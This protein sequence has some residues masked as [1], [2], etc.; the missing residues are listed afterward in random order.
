MSPDEVLSAVFDKGFQNGVESLTPRELELYRIQEFILDF[1]M[2]GL[3]GYMY[4]HLADTASIS[5]TIA[6]MQSLGLRSLAS[7]LGEA[8]ALFDGY[9]DSESLPTWKSILQKHDPHDRLDA[10]QERISSLQNYDLDQGSIV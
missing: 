8:A 9:V 5:S 10:I 2:G 1:E 6:A 7:L 3:S 4:N